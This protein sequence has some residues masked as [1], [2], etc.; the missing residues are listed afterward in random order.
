MS[1]LDDNL[2][3]ST[4]PS[5]T[6]KL[7]GVKDGDQGK[8][9]TLS[10]SSEFTLAADGDNFDGV[11]FSIDTKYPDGSYVGTVKRQP[12]LRKRAINAGAGALTVGATV[13]AAAQTVSGT[14]GLPRVKAGAG[15]WRVVELLTGA[16]AVGEE[17]V[18]EKV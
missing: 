7:V 2:S 15:G 14:E 18:I 3:N 11:I 12:M 1:T 8:P 16:G 4:Y 10:G 17:V 5:D 13:L 6:V 9:V